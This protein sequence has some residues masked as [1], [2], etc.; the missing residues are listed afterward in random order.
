MVGN[1]MA[2]SLTKAAMAVARES[3][4]GLYIYVSDHFD[5]IERLRQIPIAWNAIAKAA[6]DAGQKNSF[7]GPPSGEGMRVC[8]NRVARKRGKI[9]GKGTSGPRA[10]DEPQ[11]RVRTPIKLGAPRPIGDHS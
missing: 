5:E 6:G 4:A 2:G 3:Q 8:F 9:F 1:S 10:A 7:G 11:Q